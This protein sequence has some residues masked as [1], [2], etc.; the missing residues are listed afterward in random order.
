MWRLSLAHSLCGPSENHI[1]SCIAPQSRAWQFGANL[2]GEGQ[3]LPPAAKL[4]SRGRW[5][6][7]KWCTSLHNLMLAMRLW[8][9]VQ[10][11]RLSF[12]KVLK[13]HSG[14]T[15]VECRHSRK[16]EF[17][18]FCFARLQSDTLSPFTRSFGFLF[19]REMAISIPMGAMWCSRSNPW[20]S[21]GAIFSAQRR[22]S[23]T[24]YVHLFCT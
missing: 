19:R 7:W 6:L 15:S 9:I 23:T 4:P 22:I 3:K 21:R 10:L 1:C 11:R 16:L 14:K 17:H 2:G 20:P 18:F 24:L 5:P 13:A 8:M 12:W